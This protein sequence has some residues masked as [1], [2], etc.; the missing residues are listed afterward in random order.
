MYYS[1]ASYNTCIMKGIVS[2][3]QKRILDVIIGKYVNPRIMEDQMDYFEII[4]ILIMLYL[5]KDKHN[6]K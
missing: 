1:N 3:E 2:N 6:K 5:L 4:L